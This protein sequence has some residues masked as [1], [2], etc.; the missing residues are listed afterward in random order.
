[1]RTSRDASM[2]EGWCGGRQDTG[3]PTSREAGLARVEYSK[4]KSRGWH[5]A[6]YHG[7]WQCN[8]RTCFHSK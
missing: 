7:V 4:G 8:V 1:M 5:G 2:E 3:R 6:E